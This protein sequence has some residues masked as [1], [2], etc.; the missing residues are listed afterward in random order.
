ARSSSS[1]PTVSAARS[2]RSTTTMYG[3]GRDSRSPASPG[4]PAMRRGSSTRPS[5]GSPARRSSSGPASATSSTSRTATDERPHAPRQRGRQAGPLRGDPVA[6]GPAD[7]VRHGDDG[8]DD[9]RPRPREG[10]GQRLR[11]GEPAD[12]DARGARRRSGGAA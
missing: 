10:L 2:P 7:R 5:A 6:Q 11:R 4:T 3:S 9:D 8:R 1:S 12:E